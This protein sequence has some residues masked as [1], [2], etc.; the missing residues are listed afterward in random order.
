MIYMLWGNNWMNIYRNK[1]WSKINS[2]NSK[3]NWEYL[4]WSKIRS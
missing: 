3:R 4:E 2:Y 1:K